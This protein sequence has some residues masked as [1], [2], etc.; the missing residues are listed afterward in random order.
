MARA[1]AASVE[2]GE[3]VTVS[4]TIATGTYHRLT[5]YRRASDG[6]YEQAWSDGYPSRVGGVELEADTGSI[7]Q[8][9]TVSPA[10]ADP[11]ER[12]G[13]VLPEGKVDWGTEADWGVD[14]GPV[15]A[16]THPG[17]HSLTSPVRRGRVFT[18]HGDEVVGGPEA[19]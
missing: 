3:E 14:F 8:Q 9:R 16:V 7:I 10:S 6:S 2:H 18:P 11:L 1:R 4:I 19:K 17:P 12:Y 5:L 15:G 13:V